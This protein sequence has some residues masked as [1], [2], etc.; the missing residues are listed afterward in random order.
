M[1]TV[2]PENGGADFQPRNLCLDRSPIFFK[3]QFT[4]DA[5]KDGCE[6]HCLADLRQFSTRT[7][8]ENKY[9]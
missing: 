9:L 5:W 8:S 3:L 4:S 7:F 6:I 1:G 2:K